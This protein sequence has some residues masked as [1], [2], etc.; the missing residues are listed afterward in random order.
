MEETFQG[1]QIR[2]N[3]TQESRL[4]YFSNPV[5]EMPRGSS[6]EEAVGHTRAMRQLSPRMKAP[7]VGT[8]EMGVTAG[9]CLRRRTLLL[10]PTDSPMQGLPQRAAGQ[11]LQCM[12]QTKYYIFRALEDAAPS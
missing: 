6:G 9:R 10:S 1:Q 3:L 7:G 8:Q 5:Q 4:S 12:Q 11:K 2:G